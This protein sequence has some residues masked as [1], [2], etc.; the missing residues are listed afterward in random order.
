MSTA[1][2]NGSDSLL[3]QATE[4]QMA[5]PPENNQLGV[6][7]GQAGGRLTK[8]LLNNNLYKTDNFGYVLFNANL[9][10]RSRGVGYFSR[11]NMAA[12]SGCDER[13]PGSLV[14]C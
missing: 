8:G 5:Y 6:K 13:I 7:A 9:Q 4:H 10:T 1:T 11:K 2:L 12:G 14:G 3:V